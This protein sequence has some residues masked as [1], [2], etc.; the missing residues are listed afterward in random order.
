MLRILAP[1]M[2]AVCLLAAVN[3]Y[4]VSYQTRAEELALHAAEKRLEELSRNVATLRAE[5]DYRAR[6]DAIAPAARAIGMQPA[7]GNQFLTV[8]TDR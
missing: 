8:G 7:H 1:V 3:L 5:R 6:P 4:R 2:V